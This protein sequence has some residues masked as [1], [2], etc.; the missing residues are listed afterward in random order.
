MD[1]N[2]DREVLSAQMYTKSAFTRVSDVLRSS[3][4]FSDPENFSA[5][6]GARKCLSP[7]TKFYGLPKKG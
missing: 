7:T 5:P 1:Y 6:L 4:S 2:P 3:T